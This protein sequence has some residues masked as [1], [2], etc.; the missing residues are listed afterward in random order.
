[1]VEPENLTFTSKLKHFENELNLRKSFNDKLTQLNT[2]TQNSNDN[3]AASLS[4][5]LPPLVSDQDLKQIKENLAKTADLSTTSMGSQQQTRNIPIK[6]QSSSEQNGKSRRDPQLTSLHNEA[7]RIEPLAD[8]R[9]SIV[10]S[11]SYQLMLKTNT[12]KQ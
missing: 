8:L 2:Y 7:Y 3:K 4:P 11:N 12:F 9:V 10:L 5:K 6:I 1:M